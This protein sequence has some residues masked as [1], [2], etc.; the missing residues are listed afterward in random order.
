[1]SKAKTTKAY[2]IKVGEFDKN[3]APTLWEFGYCSMGLYY[4]SGEVEPIVSGYTIKEL[5]EIKSSFDRG[6][7]K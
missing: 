7:S 5:R 4:G 2:I 1:M 6:N 3:G